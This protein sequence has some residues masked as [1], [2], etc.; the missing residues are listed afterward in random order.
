MTLQ[1]WDLLLCCI[2]EVVSLEAG[3][4]AHRARI[5]RHRYEEGLN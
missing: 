5:D 3:K 2:G 4:T 1:Q